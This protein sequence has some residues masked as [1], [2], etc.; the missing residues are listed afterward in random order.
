MYTSTGVF[1]NYRILVVNTKTLC[2]FALQHLKRWS[3]LYISTSDL[4]ITG[5]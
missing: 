4:T 1:D 5:A 2:V 3:F